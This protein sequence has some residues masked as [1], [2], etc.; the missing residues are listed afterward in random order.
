MKRAITVIVCLCIVW[1]RLLYAQEF[2]VEEA[3]AQRAYEVFELG[4]EIFYLLYQE[5]GYMEN[6][7]ML[8][9][10]S[11]SYAYHNRIMLKG[12]GRFAFGQVDYDSENTGSAADND[13][14]LLE[15]RALLGYDFE[16]AGGRFSPYIGFGYRYLFDDSSGS[17]S[18][19]GAAGYTRHSN[20]LYS[21]IGFES[22][23]DLK[24]DW[25]TRFISEVDI[26]WYG[27]QYSEIG[28]AL[29]G[30]PTVENDQTEG[31]GFRTSIDLAK[32]FK[33]LDFAIE[34]FYRFWWVNDSETDTVVYQGST[35]TY[36]E[37]RNRTHEIGGKLALRF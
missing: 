12:E 22:V 14:F 1:P 24:D 17:L 26:F 16:R 11:G 25:Q 27:R 23:Y 7:G 31:L 15:G 37:P 18:T 5:P 35:R 29:A 9:G 3:R 2:V 30:H 13:E 32:S 21:P 28:D 4:P 33:N 34:A 8:Y 19:T 6:K 36:I 10:L 20:Y